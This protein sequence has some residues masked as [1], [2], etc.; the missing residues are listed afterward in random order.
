MKKY[1][2][3]ISYP[4]NKY[5]S[6]KDIL[7]SINDKDI[8]I[9]VFDSIDQ[10]K[11]Y[12]Y[13]IEYDEEY[14]DLTKCYLYAYDGFIPRDIKKY[15]TS[16][17]SNYVIADIDGKETYYNNVINFFD[18]AA[19]RVFCS[20]ICDGHLMNFNR[21]TGELYINVSGIEEKQLNR[22]IKT[23]FLGFNSNY[24]NKYY[25]THSE[26]SIEHD[27]VR[28]ELCERG[29]RRNSVFKKPTK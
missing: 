21:V 27:V 29:K 22:F 9:N 28:L 24:F 14:L 3:E 16:A 11:V 25:I 6:L 20:F 7:E 23:A 1:R 26:E 8:C 19:N 12:D 15:L 4:K 10:H 17:V 18:F 2:L 5:H 13:H